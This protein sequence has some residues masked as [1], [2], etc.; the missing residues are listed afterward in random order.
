MKDW[1]KL[2]KQGKVRVI[3][4]ALAD[5]FGSECVTVEP[6]PFD[7]VNEPRFYI[8]DDEEGLDFGLISL[9]PYYARLLARNGVKAIFE[10]NWINQHTIEFDGYA[11]IGFPDEFITSRIESSCGEVYVLGVVSPTMIPLKRLEQA[12]PGRPTRL[13]RFIGQLHPDLQIGSIKG[14]SGGPILGFRFGPPMAY[15]VVA[16]QSSW[17][18]HERITFGCPV[19]VLAELIA[20]WVD[21]LPEQHGG[22]DP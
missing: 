10:E 22:I 3:S 20:A 15:W 11:M 7:F 6:I 9:R 2:L 19:P 16:I 4:A 8:D 17:L 12:P 13:P 21:D 14:M 5:T 18:P 1:D